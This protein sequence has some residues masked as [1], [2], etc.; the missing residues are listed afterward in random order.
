M[1]SGASSTDTYH[2]PEMALTH[3]LPPPSSATR[4]ATAAA[5]QPDTSATSRQ[6]SAAWLQGLVPLKSRPGFAGNP[7]L[8]SQL[9]QPLHLPPPQMGHPGDAERHQAYVS[10][11]LGVGAG[12]LLPAGEQ[13]IVFQTGTGSSAPSPLEA[14]VGAAAAAGKVGGQGFQS[15]RLDGE[16]S[17]AFERRTPGGSLRE[18]WVDYLGDRL[19]S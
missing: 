3:P 8:L 6:P 11:L 10:Q 16:S 15:E 17:F 12:A 7:P 19:F 2:P 13:R 4:P 9:G 5:F 14:A 1:S 18:G